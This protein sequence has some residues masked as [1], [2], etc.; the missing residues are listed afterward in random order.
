MYKR[1]YYDFSPYAVKN[2]YGEFPVCED[3]TPLEQRALNLLKER[4]VTYG[5]I[6]R[7]LNCSVETAERL[8]SALQERKLEV[9]FVPASKRIVWTPKLK[10]RFVPIPLKFDLALEWGSTSDLHFGSKHQQPTLVKRAHKYAVGV[11]KA[12]VMLNLSLIHI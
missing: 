6:S 11:W 10:E 9:K 4:P 8:V 5:E 12:K 2:D 7:A 1:Q 3:C